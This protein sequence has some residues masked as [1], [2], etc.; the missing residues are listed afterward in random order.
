MTLQGG[1]DI[2]SADH[3]IETATREKN[4]TQKTNMQVYLPNFFIGYDK[5]TLLYSIVTIII[6]FNHVNLRFCIVTRSAL[7]GAK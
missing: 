2:I 6:C 3:A 7:P 1:N 5:K 4:A